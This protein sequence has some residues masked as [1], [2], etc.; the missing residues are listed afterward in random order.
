MRK[1]RDRG[2]IYDIKHT[3]EK[4]VEEEIRVLHDSPEE[5]KQNKTKPD[6]AIFTHTHTHTHTHTC[7]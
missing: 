2:R 3:H 1:Q 5:P 7:C 4:T 6:L